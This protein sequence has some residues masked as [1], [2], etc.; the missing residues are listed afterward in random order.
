MEL[1]LLWLVLAATAGGILS[2]L[3]GWWKANEP[4]DSRK[5]GQTVVTSFL[6]GIV[7]ALAY[8]L[9]SGALTMR[10]L[11]IAVAGGA[12][13]DAGI[14]RVIGAAKPKPPV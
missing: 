4:F 13:I 6:S 3:A 8:N 5:F 7:F 2:G 9:T 1:S 11:L 14:N 12:G 10:D